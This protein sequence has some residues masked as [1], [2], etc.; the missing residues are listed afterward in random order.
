MLYL[1]LDSSTQSL[2]A[3][4]LDLMSREVLLDHSIN[5]DERL[6][7][8]GCKNG[9]LPNADPQVAHSDPLMWLAALDLM[10]QDLVD[11]G[12]DLGQIAAVSGSGQQH[13]SVYLKANAADVLESLK[14]R[15]TLAKQLKKTLSRPTSPIWMDSCPRPVCVGIVGALGGGGAVAQLTGSA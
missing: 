2:S 11:K 14:P 10:C 3:V 8:F 12:V 9:V 15:G 4:L 13:G 5:F 1:G 6:P 7:D